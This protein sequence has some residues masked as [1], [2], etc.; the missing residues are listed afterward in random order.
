MGIKGVF[1]LLILIL[2]SSTLLWGQAVIWE[3]DFPNTQQ[4]WDLDNNWTIVDEYL[5][6]MWSPTVL[7]YDLSAISPVIDLPAAIDELIVNQWI[8]EYS[9]NEGEFAEINILADDS[10][11]NLWTFELAG[12][13]WGISSGEDLILDISDFSNTTIQIEFR[14]YGTSTYNFN[15]W[16]IFNVALTASLDHDITALDIIG[17]ETL[18]LGEEGSW[19]ISG[20]NSGL[21]S[22]DDIEVSL[23]N[24]ETLLSTVTIAGPIAVDEQFTADFTWIPDVDQVAHLWGSISLDNDDYIGNNNTQILDVNVYPEDAIHALVW[25][26]D[27][28]SEVAGVNTA[29]YIDNAL[30]SVNVIYETVS[31]LPDDLTSFDAIF[32]ALGVYCVG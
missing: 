18:I 19:T 1:I 24:G 20:V 9:A 2:L 26:N 23:M 30:S 3:S 8:F 10:S 31:A 5:S 12:V 32:V 27:N 11:T 28:S 13:D 14:C 29:E 6:L 16:N 7:D 17:T 15:N 21:N 22:E 4:V 25:D